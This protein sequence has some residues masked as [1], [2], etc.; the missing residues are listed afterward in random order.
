M[1]KKNILWNMFGL[2]V[3]LLVAVLT[4]PILLAQIGAERFGFLGLAWGL[5]GYAGI[6]DFG[7]GRAVTLQLSRNRG[8]DAE[9]D[10]NAIIRSAVF[11]TLTVSTVFSV[12]IAIA[13]FAGLGERIYHTQTTALEI[14]VTL[15]ILAGT[16]PLQ[17]ISA[18]YRGVNQAYLNFKSINILRMA[19][20]VANF[21]GPCLLSF[22]TSDLHHLVLTLFASRVVALLAY[23]ALARSCL[24]PQVVAEPGRVDYNRA[25]ALFRFGRWIALSAVISPFLIQSDRFFIGFLLS[26]AA[27]TTYIV[28]FEITTQTLI[29]VGAVTS[30]AFPAVTNLLATEPVTAFAVFRVWTRRLAL[31]MFLLM[32]GL[33][34]VFPMVLNLW[35]GGILGPDAA[36][37]GRVLCI[38]VF[39]NAIGGMYYSFLHAK[40]N[41][42]ITAL[43]H[44]AELPVFAV[45]LYVLVSQIG[46]VG[47]AIAWVCRTFIDTILLFL[48]VRSEQA[49]AR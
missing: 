26:A 22:V 27:V 24:P 47:A 17:A 29:V 16:L 41:A 11:V 1:N 44:L 6:L 39:F 49:A 23:R 33:F 48:A 3:P 7:M 34:W 12:L 8:G 40:G 9:I 14:N 2:S 46:V 5:I 43:F 10:A 15:L 42:R 18:T 30:V 31:V 13:S 28:P 25:K 45:L 32:A 20:G 19:L 38:G 21:G 35:I 37:I 4:I 36:A